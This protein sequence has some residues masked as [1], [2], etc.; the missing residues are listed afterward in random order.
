[1]GE[2][3]A[4]MS[5]VEGKKMFGFNFVNVDWERAA[6]ALYGIW[7]YQCGGELSQQRGGGESF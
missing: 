4:Q 6:S 7:K 5:V 1:M 3:D 2:R